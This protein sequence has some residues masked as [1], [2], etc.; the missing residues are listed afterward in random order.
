MLI[1]AFPTERR[2][3]TR[4]AIGDSHIL[5]VPGSCHVDKFTFPAHFSVTFAVKR[6]GEKPPSRLAFFPRSFWSAVENVEERGKKNQIFNTTH[7]YI[8]NLH[9]NLI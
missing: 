4:E 1:S 2:M 9:K 3:T 7:A 6:G 8:F 5:S